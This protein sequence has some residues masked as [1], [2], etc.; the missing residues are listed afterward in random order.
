ME[1][2]CSFDT[3]FTKNVPHIME[4]IFLSLDPASFKACLDVSKSWNEVLTKSLKRKYFAM[5]DPIIIYTFEG[6]F[7]SDMTHIENKPDFHFPK[8]ETNIY[9]IKIDDR[10]LQRRLTLKDIKDRCPRKD[11]QYYRYFFKTASEGVEVYKEM[12]DDTAVVPMHI[13][14]KISCVL[15]EIPGLLKICP[16]NN[17]Q[18]QNIN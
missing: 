7:E 2:S 10:S 12:E 3:L 13:S 15:F 11:Q 8:T 16:K 5:L 6:T 1:A 18:C 14:R 17:C 9:L 4:K